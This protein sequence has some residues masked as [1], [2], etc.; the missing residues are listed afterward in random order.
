MCVKRGEQ[1]RVWIAGA[2]ALALLLVL[3]GGGLRPG[4]GVEAG[5][6]PLPGHPAPELSLS[7]LDGAPVSLAD[8]RGKAVLVNFWATWCGPCRIELPELTAFA[9]AL[10]PGTAVLSVDM[11]DTESS[12]A[13]VARFAREVGV[14]FPV[15]LDHDGAAARRFR[16]VSV[17]TNFFVAADG[18]IAAKVAGPLTRPAMAEYLGRAAVSSERSMTDALWQLPAPPA[19]INLGGPAV[20]VPLAMAFAG[21]WLTAWL[22]RRRAGDYGLPGEAFFDLV[23]YGGLAALLASRLVYALLDPLA[24]LRKP[25]LLLLQGG[26]LGTYAALAVGL[27]W[28]A[29]RLWRLAGRD[30]LAAALDALALPAAWGAALALLGWPDPAALGLAALLAGTGLGLLW[31]ARRQPPA[32]AQALAALAWGGL[33]AVIADF[34]HPVRSLAG[35][36]SPLQLAAAALALSAAAWA[37]RRYPT[38]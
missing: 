28:L 18:R 21:A 30:K 26:R 19:S 9:A 27:G 25:W 12:P 32:G 17:P 24:Y 11:T 15:L 35:G 23:L 38:P 13:A 3:V 33:A 7:T 2:A 14:N 5:A 34:G 22:A 4:A 31:L 6:A 29:W 16:V 8:L 36:V 37:W 10:P 1:M 20:Q